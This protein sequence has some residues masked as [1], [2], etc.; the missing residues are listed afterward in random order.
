[1]STSGGAGPFI[2]LLRPVCCW[3]FSVSFNAIRAALHMIW[4][5]NH[6]AE[7]WVITLICSAH[8]PISSTA[9]R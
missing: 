3:D 9:S 2:L 1:M 4:R 6:S 5:K 7:A 8:A